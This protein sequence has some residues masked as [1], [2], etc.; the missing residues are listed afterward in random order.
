L[1]ETPHHLM[2]HTHVPA[3]STP[4]P[5]PSQQHPAPLKQCCEAAV[6]SRGS[7]GRLG[8]CDSGRRHGHHRT[9]LDTIGQH[10]RAAHPHLP[11]ALGGPPRPTAA[12]AALLLPL[13]TGLYTPLE[14]GLDGPPPSRGPPASSENATSIKPGQRLLWDIAVISVQRLT[15]CVGWL[16]KAHEATGRLP[17]SASDYDS[18]SDY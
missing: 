9:R 1:G 18:A 8:P 2:L 16:R 15:H 10:P 17:C 11:R 3:A 13:V 7:L 6:L 5:R 4:S 12:T 14:G